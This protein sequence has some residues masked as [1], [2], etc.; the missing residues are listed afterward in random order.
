MNSRPSPSPVTPS[1]DRSF[2]HGYAHPYHQPSLPS[3]NERRDTGPE[4]RHTD[5]NHR[6][7]A[8]EPYPKATP[9]YPSNPLPVPFS[10][11]P[12]QY[13]PNTITPSN[14]YV[15][16]APRRP[17]GPFSPGPRSRPAE[18]NPSRRYSITQANSL[19]PLQFPPTDPARN[20]HDPNSMQDIRHGSH[21]VK[22]PNGMDFLGEQFQPPPTHIP[23]PESQQ[24]WG[25]YYT[26]GTG[27]Q[28]VNNEGYRG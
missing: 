2:D 3:Y 10:P 9:S 12:R 14:P 5:Y 8:Y 19:P 17:S 25:T 15:N 18:F 6:P 20:M 26:S 21:D 11:P 27:Y 1:Y 13:T 24:S 16:A 7:R 22:Q 28:G 4:R 23:L